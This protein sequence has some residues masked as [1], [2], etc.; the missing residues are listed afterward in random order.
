MSLRLISINEVP[1]FC[2]SIAVDVE[3][4]TLNYR[5]IDIITK[6]KNCKNQPTIGERFNAAMA[7]SAGF[8]ASVVSGLPAWRGE[9]VDRLCAIELSGDWAKKTVHIHMGMCFLERDCF[10][11]FWHPKLLTPGA[12][13]HY[14]LQ[15]L[16]HTA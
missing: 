8:N 14:L 4:P 15:Y 5:L 13:S 10:T 11:R 7:K 9:G 12:P 16:V 6:E 2:F 1:F 3:M